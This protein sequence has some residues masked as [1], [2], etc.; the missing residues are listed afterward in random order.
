MAFKFL[1]GLILS[2]TAFG[3]LRTTDF[4]QSLNAKAPRNY[5]KNSG[6]EK[7]A[8]FGIYDPNNRVIR[9]TTNPLEGVASFEIAVPTSTADE[10][11]WEAEPLQRGLWG[12]NCVASFTY[13]LNAA[14]YEV[15]VVDENTAPVS[16]TV[17]LQNTES[18]S[19]TPA[20]KVE[21]PFP[22]GASGGTYRIFMSAT[23][24]QSS[25]SFKA[26]SFYLGEWDGVG[27]V[28]QPTFIGS[29][30]YTGQASCSWE[31]TGSSTYGNFAADT[32]CAT[33]STV[34]SVSAPGTKI[35][36]VVL[37][38]APAGRYVVTANF[39]GRKNGTADNSVQFRLSDGTTSG[40][41]QGIYIST[42]QTWQFPTALN[43]SFTYTTS[44]P[45]L[46][47]QVQGATL[48]TSNTVIIDNTVSNVGLTFNVV[49]YPLTEGMTVR[50]N[51]PG[52]NWTSY[53]PVITY[54]SGGMTN[55]THSLRYK[56]V[57]PI[58]LA[59]EGKSA[60]TG[61]S[62]AYSTP[63]YSLPSGAVYNGTQNNWSGYSR[64]GVIQGDTSAAV[65]DG[66]LVPV[67][68]VP[69]TSSVSTSGYTN[70]DAGAPGSSL[71]F[72]HFSIPIE[73][74]FC[75]ASPA[76]YIK[77]GVVYDTTVRAEG[78]NGVT[79]IASGVYAPTPVNV[80]NVAASSASACNYQR[81]GA[82]VNVSCRVSLTCTA[83]SNTSTEFYL[84]LPVA[85]D[86]S[87]SGDLNGV[88]AGNPASGDT[89]G[90]CFED[91][92]GDRAICRFGCGSTDSLLGRR[93]MFQYEVK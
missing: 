11:E 22:C 2:T 10:F 91:T 43:S 38:N 52:I 73:P 54:T 35:P 14:G 82:V 46:T 4:Q 84:A 78:L 47:F 87:S 16:A 49:Y 7:N 76:A 88:V 39:V 17:Q 92:T 18:G 70:S 30:T 20:N 61:T 60:F 68:L 89:A 65:S 66:K 58:T 81:S 57:D 48:N 28:A 86:L 63:R 64:A 90:T 50:L 59:V 74:G 6:A 62:A 3:Q 83:A 51:Q 41:G 19:I 55:V 93:L 36:G 85:S 42:N 44:Q 45:T 77:Q 29:L 31:R 15:V 32:D 37:T 80:T 23:G 8:D 56:C 25:L 67:Y 24:T 33:P 12:K 72:G 21:L 5:I 26:D 75:P 13:S 40:S 71:E 27:S 53:T 1:L 69:G 9:T 34:G 79:S